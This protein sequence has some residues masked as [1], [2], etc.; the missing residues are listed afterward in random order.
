MKSI[1]KN[2]QKRNI[3]N[4]FKQGSENNKA[5]L[6]LNKQDKDYD[7]EANRNANDNKFKQEQK[8]AKYDEANQTRDFDMKPVANKNLNSN[9]Q[10]KF[11][12]NASSSDNK[13]NQTNINKKHLDEDYRENVE[14]DITKKT[15]YHDNNLVKD[16]FESNIKAESL[17]NKKDL[18]KE[19]NK[20]GHDWN[21]Y[22]NEAPSFNKKI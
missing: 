21:Q 12:Q 9:K 19:V 2:I 5:S 16:A 17:K 1:F 7:Q 10:E 4:I 11:D 6:N 8:G 3:I 22:E 14:S 20:Q 15:A 18:N 13:M